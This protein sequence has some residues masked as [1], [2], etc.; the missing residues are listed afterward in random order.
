M[1][2]LALKHVIGELNDYFYAVFPPLAPASTNRERVLAAPL[3]DLDGNVNT[4]AKDRVVAQV[5]NVQ[6]DRVYHSVDVFRRRD[7]GTSELIHPEIKVNVFVLFIANISDYS[8][9][10]KMLSWV[11]AF[12]QHRNTF[13]YRAIPGLSG[14]EGHFIFELYSMT[15]EQQN[16]LWGTLGAKYMPSVMFKL[17]LVDIRDEQLRAEVP[18]VLDIAANQPPPGA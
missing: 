5:V 18:P 11:M 7:D 13:D 15:L 9:A 10:M 17:G 4:K 8:E 2:D 16:Y 3:F 12:F 6:E 1:I 14:R